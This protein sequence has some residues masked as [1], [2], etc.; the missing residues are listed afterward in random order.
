MR[1]TLREFL[2]LMTPDMLYTD[3][4]RQL[5]EFLVNHPDFHGK[6]EEVKGLQS[7]ADYVKIESLLYE[8]LYQ[9]LELNELHYEA[10]RL[11]TRLIE[12]FVKTKKADIAQ[13]LETADEA[14]YRNLLEQAKTYDQLLKQVK[15]GVVS[16]G[17]AAQ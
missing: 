2:Q 7:L 11:Q 9:G 4:G 12:A 13:A 8:E 10:A 16:Y 6:L 15:G 1:P 3:N 14:A 5:L 17:E